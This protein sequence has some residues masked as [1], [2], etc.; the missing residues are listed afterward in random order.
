MH[1]D[2]ID[3]AYDLSSAAEDVQGAFATQFGATEGT[4]GL[5]EG[6]Q[7]NALPVMPG[8]EGRAAQGARYTRVF[9]NMTFAA[10]SDALW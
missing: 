3:S 7:D 9:P 5:L 6:D 1:A 2:P 4:G 8:L 10:N